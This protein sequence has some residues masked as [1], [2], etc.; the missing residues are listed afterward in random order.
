MFIVIS[1]SPI[2]SFIMKCRQC[3]TSRVS[4]C[5]CPQATAQQP[6]RQR[7]LQWLQ[8]FSGRKSC[9]RHSCD[10]INRWMNML[11]QNMFLRKC[12]IM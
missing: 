6:Q 7:C 10:E 8:V 11:I 1:G 12:K 3:V 2:W 5:R 4:S 9:R